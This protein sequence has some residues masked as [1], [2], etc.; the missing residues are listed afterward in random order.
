M[1]YAFINNFS[2]AIAEDIT[3]T[4]TGI[5]LGDSASL[6]SE[7]STKNKY[8]LT[9]FDDDGNIEIVYVRS[10]GTT[11]VGVDRGQEGTTQRAWPA[12]T[13]IE[14]R[15][16]AAIANGIFVVEPTDAAGTDAVG[17][18][19]SRS[20]ADQVASGFSSVAIGADSK[21]SDY[22][23]VALGTFTTATASNAAALGPDSHAE[24]LQ[25]LAVGSACFANFPQAIAVGRSATADSDRAT[26]IGPYSLDHGGSADGIAFGAYASINGGGSMSMGHNSATAAGGQ[27]A[28]GPNAYPNQI[29][30]AMDLTA[31]PVMRSGI[32][33]SQSYQHAAAMRVTLPT[34]LRTFA[35]NL[36]TTGD[37]DSITL[38]A[39]TALMIDR[40]EIVVTSSAA[41]GSTPTVSIGTTLGGAEILS[42]HVMAGDTVLRRE[43]LVTS[44]V[45]DAV[46]A[47]Y[48]K[49]D[50]AAAA[51]MEA[52]FVVYGYVTEV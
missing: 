30:S 33:T 5:I 25:A 20:T 27:L 2:E 24:A 51:A 15:F 32:Q 39:S 48:F 22:I 1:P 10:A 9:L 17:I 19:P 28:L 13:S 36:A 4:D 12:G 43:Q 41:A 50:A 14:S 34:L 37:K 40:I 23:A 42:G 7:A 35:V 6:F 16:T 29:Q 44:P 3:D 52:R 18:Q 31:I 38:P 11:G 8:P 46:T 49:V 45:A 26:V 47:L 21:A